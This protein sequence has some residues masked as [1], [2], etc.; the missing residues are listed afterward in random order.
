VARVVESRLPL[1]STPATV[2]GLSRKMGVT[3]ARIYQLLEESE[4]A[5][6]LRWPEGRCYLTMLTERV[7]AA[8]PASEVHAALRTTM[9]VFFPDAVEAARRAEDS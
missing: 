8:Q 1:R 2:H 6:D 5:I 7:A 9:N 4:A 3:R